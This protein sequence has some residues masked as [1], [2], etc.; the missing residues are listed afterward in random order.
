MEEKNT[1]TPKSD[2][3]E[4]LLSIYQQTDE[5]M[6][7]QLFSTARKHQNGILKAIAKKI[8]GQRYTSIASRKGSIG[9]LIDKFLES[10]KNADLLNDLLATFMNNY[11]FI[12]DKY[13]AD[14]FVGSRITQGRFD[15]ML[16]QIAP[17][18]PARNHISFCFNVGFHESDFQQIWICL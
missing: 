1:L 7:K 13:I 6:R 15:A 3:P 16:D 2:A 11:L 12:N 10:P 18:D 9:Q 14:H 4:I 5:Q 17:D 8:P